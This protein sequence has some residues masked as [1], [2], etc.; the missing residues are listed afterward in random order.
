[1]SRRSRGLLGLCLFVCL[2]Q[3]C[4]GAGAVTFDSRTMLDT[5]HIKRGMRAVGK[6][7]FA[8]TT[9]TQFNLVV[10]DVLHKANAGGD[11]ILAR[12]L[13]GP[14][15]QRQSGIIGGMSGSPVYIN[16]KLIGA[17]AYGWGFPKEPIC[18]ITAIRDMLEA[19][20][21]MAAP[22]KQSLLPGDTRQKWTCSQPLTVGGREYRTA[23]VVRPGAAAAPGII[24][25]RPCAPILSCS[26]L[27]PK[28]LGILRQTLEPYG[29]EP[30]A[31]GGSGGPVVPVTLQ[32]GS[33]LG[34]RFMKGDFDATGI[35]T[36]TYRKGDKLVGF[37]H[38]MMQRGEVSMP[39]CT[40][41]ISDFLPS[42]QRSNKLGSGMLDVGTLR[43]DTAWSVGAQIGPLPNY[44][45]ADIEI[46]DQTRNLRKKFHVKVLSEKGVTSGLLASAV[47]S[48]L[49]ASF[50]PGFEGM[51]RTEFE[52]QGVRGAHVKR[53]NVFYSG[54][55]PADTALVEAMDVMRML[56]DNRWE[57]QDVKRLVFRAELNAKDETAFIEK[58]S[59][60][61]NVAK[62]GKTLNLHI[63]VRPDDGPPQ[64]FPVTLNLPRELPKGSLRVA[65]VGGQ[66]AMLF[67]SRLGVLL[68]E[69]EDLAP[70]LAFY[71][72]LEDNRQLCVI[73]ALPSEGLLVGATR[74]KRLPDAM[75]AIFEKSSRTDLDKGRDE[76]TVTKELPWAVFGRAMFAIATEDRMG[77]KG[78][79]TAAGA[80]RPADGE[81]PPSEDSKSGFN[82]PADRLWWAAAAFGPRAADRPVRERA[83]LPTVTVGADAS[84]P[85][86]AE[87][88]VGA[89]PKP[90]DPQD[91]ISYQK[92]AAVPA[93]AK[94]EANPIKKPDIDEDEEEDETESKTVVRQPTTWTQA[95]P[96]DFADGE[97]KGTAPR[98]DGGMSLAPACTELGAV[99]EIYAMATLVVGDQT[100]VGTAS[101]GRLYR[102]KA[103]GKAELVFDTKQFAIRSL[104]A[105][106]EGRVYLGTFPGGQVFRVT[107]DGQGAL[108]CQ[109][110][111]DYVWSLAWAKDGRL[112]AGTGPDG[113]LFGIN[114][115]GQVT[116]VLKVPQA[117]ILCLLPAGD[118]VYLGTADQGLVY[119]LTAAGKLEAAYDA[120]TQDVTCL[121]QD[122]KGALYAGLAPE[123]KI[124]R[125]ETGQ[126]P[127]T[128]FTD[129]NHPVY[130]LAVAAG[131]LYAATGAEGHLLALVEDGVYDLVQDTEALHGLC[132]APAADGSLITGL[133]NPG[134]VLRLSPEAPS[135]GTFTSAVLDADRPARWGLISWLAEVP[136]AA[137]LA[138]QTRSGSSSDPEDGSWS[139]WS[140]AY[141]TAAGEAISSPPARYLQ[142]R[143][144]FSKAPGDGVPFL[145]RLCV[146]YL[147]AN[148]PPT[149][150]IDGPTVESPAHGEA[151]VKWTA[152]DADKDQVRV[153]VAYRAAGTAEWQALTNLPGDKK[154]Y[155]WDTTKVADGVYDLRLTVTDEVSN[156]GAGL[157]DTQV[158]YG[159]SV[160]NAKPVLAITKLLVQDGK[161]VV[162]GT[163]TD[164]GRVTEVTYQKGADWY[165]VAAGDGAYGGAQE[166]F[167]FTVPLVDGK[168]EIKLQARDAADNVIT[169]PVKWPK[170]GTGG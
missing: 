37:G 161:L 28:A 3:L 81:K 46:V 151:E 39:L 113:R 26:G 156:P 74:L 137:K 127:V 69:F 158:L 103:D 100:F 1:M 96:A 12:V 162:E 90:L 57:P 19:M 31:S 13:D 32:A 55:S 133:A 40:A 101:P 73:A 142:Y 58:V 168:V 97:P 17:I 82:P 36:V 135:S 146:C 83:G 157:T 132:F 30:V 154:S 126:P 59:C 75:G 117:H 22:K 70:L 65:V 43:A 169:Q 115:Q 66:D 125:L 38:P 60:E 62:A 44:R 23:Q 87:G 67:R 9:I 91:R 61:E 128:V 51:I 2:L 160:D 145:H 35:G 104:V 41:W 33:A 114:D 167:A 105:D 79:V 108:F 93:P 7:V 124:V 106:K 48:A 159:V 136:A 116:E 123:G 5:P 89:R 54:G 34:V 112:L 131:R 118:D 110:P 140:A 16:G 47:A 86:P 78:T 4:G 85:Q 50:N 94:V 99:P 144:E 120:T 42:Y 88:E 27:G 63:Q 165:G 8:G 153:A 98:S 20:D 111:T 92:P 164:N 10:L 56:E 139:A 6:T 138:V 102:V 130:A 53:S 147:P 49:E 64:D 15:V 170:N 45:P 77:G 134:K 11:M 119:R 71:E 163:A 166:T 109:L 143:L 80:K 24:P 18:G 14:V 76:I 95:K 129:K 25:L 21:I 72:K 152:T 150:K 84:G 29:I 107:P 68:P 52:V 148:Q 122:A 155:K 141:A 149:I 121:A